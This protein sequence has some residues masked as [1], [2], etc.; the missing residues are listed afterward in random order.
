MFDAARAMTLASFPPDLP[1]DERRRRLFSRLYG[2][3]V[4]PDRVPEPL[5]PR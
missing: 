2:N 3:D 4:R 1:A 5:R